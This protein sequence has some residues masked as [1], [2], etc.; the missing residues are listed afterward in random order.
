MA[1]KII[2]RLCLCFLLSCL[3]NMDHDKIKRV[4]VVYG[5]EASNGKIIE[6]IATLERQGQHLSDNRRCHTVES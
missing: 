5:R 6:V 3:S 4:G 1:L 2:V